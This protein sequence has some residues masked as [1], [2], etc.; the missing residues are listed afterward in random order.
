[1]PILSLFNHPM[2]QLIYTKIIL[3][4]RAVMVCFSLSLNEL[5]FR[6]RCS[7]LNFLPFYFLREIQEFL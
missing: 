5:N 2:K 3:N 7:E 6:E 4:M 1:M